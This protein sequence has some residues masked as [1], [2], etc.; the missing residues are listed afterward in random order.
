MKVTMYELLGMIKDGKAPKKIKFNNIYCYYRECK[1]EYVDF[2]NKPIIK[3]DYVVMNSLNKEVEII[4]EK[5]MCHKCHK[6][7]AE[8]NQTYCEFCLGI[9]KLEE[10]KIPEKID[11]NHLQQIKK[12]KRAKILGNKINEILDYLEEIQ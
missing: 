11:V 12:W 6:Y 4:E 10:H 3:W 5:E 2:A 1:N 8:Y 9:S 7:P